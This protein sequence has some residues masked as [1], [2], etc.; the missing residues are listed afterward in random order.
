MPL[1]FW[2]NFIDEVEVI[3]QCSWSD[4]LT[5]FYVYNAG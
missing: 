3:L 2:G 5:V 4:T 1:H